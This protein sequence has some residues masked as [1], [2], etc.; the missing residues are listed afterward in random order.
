M[1]DPSTRKRTIIKAISWETFSTLATFCVAWLMFGN[2]GTCI[3]FATTTFLM[4]LVLFYGH[5]RLWHQIPYGKSMEQRCWEAHKRGE[6]QP[7]SDVIEE[8][9]QQQAGE[10]DWR[11]FG[12]R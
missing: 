8:L 9:K 1:R 3:V 2:L 12:G 6:S 4:K 11:R 7:L 10:G 5:D